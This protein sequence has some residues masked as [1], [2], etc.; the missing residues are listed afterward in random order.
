MAWRRFLLA[1]LLIAM[2]LSWSTPAGGE[3]L[4]GLIIAAGPVTL[5]EADQIWTGSISVTNPT[6]EDISVV[7]APRGVGVD[8]NRCEVA[9]TKGGVVRRGTSASVSVTVAATDDCDDP[10]DGDHELVLFARSH[11]VGTPQ[12]ITVP[13]AE[14]TDDSEPEETGLELPTESVFLR[15]SGDE[16]VGSFDV[17]N[18]TA[19]LVRVTPSVV[20]AN[21]SVSPARPPGDGTDI[22]P[23]GVEP[24]DVNVPAACER[25]DSQTI[26]VSV[27]S[28]TADGKK[29]DYGTIT[30]EAEVHWSGLLVPGI[31]ILILAALAA[32]SG[33]AHGVQQFNRTRPGS[34]RKL[35]WN[36]PLVATAD[37]PKSWLTAVAT[38]GPAA[39]ALFSTT[40]LVEGLTGD[41]PTA[42]KTLVLVSTAV[43]LALV[44]LA[45]TI[46]NIPAITVTVEG[47]DQD[48]PRVWQFVLAAGL[49]TCSAGLG[50]ASVWSAADDLALPGGDGW[51]T[52][53]GIVLLLGLIFYA[54]WSVKRYISRFGKVWPPPAS[55]IPKVVPPE[56][57]AGALRALAP[58]F[59]GLGTIT[60]VDPQVQRRWL[61]AS[62][63]VAS[64]LVDV[65]TVVNAAQAIAAANA[66]ATL[67]AQAALQASTT[68][69]V[70]PEAAQA[71]TEAAAQARDSADQAQVAANS[72]DDDQAR[73]LAEIAC[74]SAVE[75]VH[76]TRDVA[77][78]DA[79]ALEEAKTLLEALQLLSTSP[80]DEYPG[81]P[82]STARRPLTRSMI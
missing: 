29:Y 63:T 12:V 66:A 68:A 73:Q 80:G 33:G 50:L 58:N 13:I 31:G 39:T 40:N 45:T 32:L 27:L 4:D 42:P 5:S 75:A 74:L 10:T 51:I 22:E 48:C 59:L 14:A 18:T 30:V 9:V 76:A 38:I 26:L 55:S 53:G 65:P 23:G 44:G 77:P 61:A 67:A 49:T 36:D 3:P 62:K 72:G 82:L 15:R 20:G 2:G 41:D 37:A 6:T 1:A 19:A 11:A 46:A 47:K 64:E 25:L 70:A 43:A 56:L 79:A 35:I 78:G 24:I 34:M 57:L 81:P 7:P 8:A 21:C 52:V 71:V 28:S 16:L 17:A 54:Y 60:A 69:G